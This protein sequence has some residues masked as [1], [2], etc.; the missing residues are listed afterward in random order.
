MAHAIQVAAAAAGHP[1]ALP[2]LVATGY[3]IA[4]HS[5]D[6]GVKM[7]GRIASLRF[8]EG[9]KVRRGEV[10][11]VIEHADLDAQLEARAAPSARRRPQL[12]QTTAARDEDRAQPRAA[13]RAH[14]GRHHDDGRAH[15]RRVGGRRVGGAR[16]VGRGGDRAARRRAWT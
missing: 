6:V 4:R 3:V 2:V 9:T 14:E 7:G 10:M 12:A 15:R 11:A 8:E 16:D 1:G 13:A 5:S